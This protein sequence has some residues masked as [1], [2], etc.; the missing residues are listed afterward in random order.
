M[1]K[2]IIIICILFFSNLIFSQSKPD[3]V[4]I[5]RLG[6]SIQLINELEKNIETNLDSIDNYNDYF[7]KL[8]EPITI[9]KLN[10]NEDLHNIGVYNCNKLKTYYINGYKING[11]TLNNIY[12]CFYDNK[13]SFIE[14]DNVSNDLII[15]LV[16]KFPNSKTI[17]KNKKIICPNNTT[18]ICDDCN[19]IETKWLYKTFTTV[20]TQWYYYT[21]GI[22]TKFDGND[23]YIPCILREIHKLT[24]EATNFKYQIK[25]HKSK[26][27]NLEGL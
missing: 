11:L 23:P 7:K 17:L 3:G 1:K 6:K 20:E 5:I 4:G 24:I 15:S 9:T 16:T 25:C 26:T 22:N 19:N 12:L 18:I 13:L 2:K 14:F 8:S 10:Y 27:I 21:D